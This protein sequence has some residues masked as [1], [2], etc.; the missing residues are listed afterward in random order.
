M[1][2]YDFGKWEGY[3]YELYDQEEIYPTE[4]W[5]GEMTEKEFFSKY[6]KGETVIKHYYRWLYMVTD[7]FG[8]V[9]EYDSGETQTEKY[10]INEEGVI[11][12]V[13]VE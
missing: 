4:V 2:V 3:S 11:T 10:H 1:T 12:H 13:T 9:E 8:S 6:L 5:D 7:D